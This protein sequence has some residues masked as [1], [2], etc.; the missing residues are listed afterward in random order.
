ML[1]SS[2]L[3][4]FY[5]FNLTVNFILLVYYQIWYHMKFRNHKEYIVRIAQTVSF[6]MVLLYSQDD[7][8]PVYM[9]R[10]LLEETNTT[11]SSFFNVSGC[12]YVYI[13]S[14]TFTLRPGLDN[15]DKTVFNLPGTHEFDKGSSSCANKS[16][17]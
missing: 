16:G 2:G 3:V 7:T 17:E 14:L 9:G 13:N 1:Y 11:E 4:F 12:I 5:K 6:Q 10:H 15:P 8:E